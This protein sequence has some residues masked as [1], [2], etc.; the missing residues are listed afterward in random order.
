MISGNTVAAIASVYPIVNSP[1]VGSASDSMSLT[2]WRLC[3][4]RHKKH[5]ADIRI[6]PSRWPF[7]LVIGLFGPA[8]RHNPG[9]HTGRFAVD[10]AV[11][12]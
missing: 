3:R 2:P 5:Y 9:L 7:V 8:Y 4:Y 11:F 10:F 12:T 6:M 1:V